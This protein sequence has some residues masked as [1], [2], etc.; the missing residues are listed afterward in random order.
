MG[1]GLAA[2]LLLGLLAMNS[3]AVIYYAE[4]SPGLVD[5][6][7]RFRIVVLSPFVPE[8]IVK[9]IRQGGSVVLG[10]ISIASIG[11]WEPWARNVSSDLVIGENRFWG[12]RIINVCKPGWRRV[13]ASATKYIASK[14][15]SGFFLDNLDVVDE[16][17]WMKPCI[18]RLIRD[19]RSWYP[20]L[21][22]MVN[23]GFTLL[24]DIARYIDYVLF[25]DFIT[26]YDTATHQYRFFTGK[27]LDWINKTIRVIHG[28]GEKYGIRLYLLAYAPLDNASFLNK[29]CELREKIDP[30]DP[31]YVATWRLDTLGLC[32]PCAETN[33]I[34]EPTKLGG[35]A[36][37]VMLLIFVLIPG[38]VIARKRLFIK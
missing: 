8:S 18:I 31:L 25:E 34:H 30:R 14:G 37:A 2:V 20:G 3:C 33:N 15:F 11:G 26:Y 16:Y 21:R 29:L 22:I 36:L 35:Y 5:R 32:N 24:P 7:S 6:L 13:I 28:L 9:E 1:P 19:I 17:P 4:V 12:E 10:Y 23:R 38:L 27:D